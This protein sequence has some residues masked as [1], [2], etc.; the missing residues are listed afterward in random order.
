MTRTPSARTANVRMS[1]RGPVLDSTE[2][3]A[4]MSVALTRTEYPDNGIVTEETPTRGC[5]RDNVRYPGT[6]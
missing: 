3:P 4:R 5:Q 1:L 2:R 6:R